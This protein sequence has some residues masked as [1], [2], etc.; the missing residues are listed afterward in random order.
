MPIIDCD[1]AGWGFRLLTYLDS[2]IEVELVNCDFSAHNRLCHGLAERFS[3]RLAPEPENKT[4]QFK[5]TGV[6]I[7]H[8]PAERAADDFRV[9]ISE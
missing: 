5:L 2:Q 9:N 3:M 1:I 8:A 4:I 7:V 6:S